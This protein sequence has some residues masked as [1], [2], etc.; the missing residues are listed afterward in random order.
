MKPSNQNNVRAL[1]KV[2]NP[3]NHA[4]GLRDKKVIDGLVYLNC[5]LNKES[6]FFILK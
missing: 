6:S 4:F 3:A 5:F 1:F 2:L